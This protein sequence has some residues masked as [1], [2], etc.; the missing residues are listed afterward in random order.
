MGTD[1]DL[2]PDFWT[3]HCW[4]IPVCELLALAFF[5]HVDDQG[6]AATADRS[7]SVIGIDPQGNVTRQRAPNRKFESCEIIGMTLRSYLASVC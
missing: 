1:S 4:K 6:G 7:T 3:G 5:Q 2:F